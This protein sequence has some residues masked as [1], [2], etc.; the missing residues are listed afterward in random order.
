MQ[1]FLIVF[2]GAGFGGALR[3]GVN[4]AAVRV[5]EE[6]FPWGTLFINAAG[7]LAMGLLAGFLLSRRARARRKVGVFF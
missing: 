6:G 4:M 7:S 3:H 5:A 2:L 1:S